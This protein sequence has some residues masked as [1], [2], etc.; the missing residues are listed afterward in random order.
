MYD[1]MLNGLLIDII[2]LNYYSMQVDLV[3]QMIFL[4]VIELFLL[5]EVKVFDYSL[6]CLDSWYVK[7]EQWFCESQ[8]SQRNNH[9]YLIIIKYNIKISKYLFLHLY[10]FQTHQLIH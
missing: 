4:E 8:I 2:W 5:L 6:D 9:N 1:Q 3:F 10:K 7:E